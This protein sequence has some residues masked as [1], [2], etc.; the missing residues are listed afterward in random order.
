M[1]LEVNIE[2]KLDGFTL[3]AAFSAGNTP[4]ALLGASGCGK[5]MTLRCIAG[6]V[7]PDKGRIVLDGRVLFDSEQHIDLPPQ[8]RNVG[9]LFQNYALFPNMT[10]EQNIL[11]AL[12]KEKDPAAR[13]AA[14]AEAL[15]AMRLEELAK[16]LPGALSGG[17]QQRAAL[18][19]ILASRPEVLL[20][21][22]PFTGMDPAAVQASIA[23]LRERVEGRPVLLATHDRAAIDA[24]GWPVLELQK[25]AQPGA[26][27]NSTNK[28]L[29]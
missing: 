27:C 8:Q 24:L 16:R 4:T 25:L 23:L 7:K 19:R 20:L 9:L 1:S 6:I 14:C 13:R 15:R 12:K 17:Q 26:A 11:C 18:A 5:S 29:Q 10:V 28:G 2:K 21:D 22:E 3:R